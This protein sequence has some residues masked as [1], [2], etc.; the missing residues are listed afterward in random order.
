MIACGKNSNGPE[1]P[2]FA[3]WLNPDTMNYERDPE[4]DVAA[5]IGKVAGRQERPPSCPTDT[6]ISI[7]TNNPLKKA[8]LVIALM[9]RTGCQKSLAYKCIRNSEESGMIRKGSEGKTMMVV[10]PERTT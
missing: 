2:P 8:D 5:G 10:D 3:I 4:F 6:V 1:F 7:L 9:E